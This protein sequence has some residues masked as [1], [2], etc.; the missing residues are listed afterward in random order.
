MADWGDQGL[1]ADLTDLWEEDYASE[2][3]ENIRKACQHSNGEYYEFPVCMTAHCM[4]INYD[5]FQEA[6]SA[7]VVSGSNAIPSKSLRSFSAR[8]F[9]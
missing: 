7:D 9:S 1:L 6:S 5:L 4:A 3:Y 2:I 8:L